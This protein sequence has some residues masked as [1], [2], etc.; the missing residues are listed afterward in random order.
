MI[1]E[2]NKKETINK[3]GR[4]IFNYRYIGNHDKY[5]GD[6]MIKKVKDNLIDYCF[7]LNNNIY[8]CF[9]LISFF[10]IIYYILN[11]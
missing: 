8:K 5:S 6:N 7:T 3:R 9:I 10:F 4:R 11:S 1:N 2:C